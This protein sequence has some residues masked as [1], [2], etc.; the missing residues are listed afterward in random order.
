MVVPLLIRGA[1][2]IGTRVVPKVLPFLGRVGKFFVPKTLKG[3]LIAAATIPA[4]IGVA[5]TKPGRKI[6]STVFD[7]RKGFA[8]GQATPEFISSL[9]KGIKEGKVPSG[10]TGLQ[11]AG[12]IGGAAALG[13]GALVIGK[14]AKEKISFFRGNTGAPAV[15]FA[16]TSQALAPVKQ[17]PEPVAVMP[18]EA[19]QKPVTIKNIFKP[20]I[21]ISFRKS[22][23]F[24]NQQNLIRA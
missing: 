15:P 1:A 21:D 23:R 11:K 5:T 10:L 16:R 19:L 9:G 22:K 20:S 17:I 14:K 13:A 3:S 8:R 4:T 6:I 24:I 2:L 18:V 7:P 12:L